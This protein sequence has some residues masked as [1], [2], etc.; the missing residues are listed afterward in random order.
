M[1]TRPTVQR[2][3]PD[4]ESEDLLA[5]AREI[6][7]EELAPLAAEYEEKEI[8]P[9]EQF[10]ILG[11]AG[12][13]GLPYPERWGGGDVPYEVYLQVLEEIAAAW[14]S[15]GVGLS[16]H[17]MSCYALAHYGSDEQRDRW[18]PAMLGGDLL[19]AYALSEP[20]AGSDAAAL[21]TRARRDGDAYVVNGVK[22]WTTHGGQAD[23]YTTMVRTS[24]DGGKGISCLLVD[25]DTPGMSAAP[26]ERKMGLTGSTTA[27]MIFEDARVDADR[28]IGA[29][30][31]GLRIALSSLASGR[32]GIAA[33]S[34]GLAQAALDEAVAYAKQRTQFGKPII[35]FQ[36][37]EFLLADMAAAVESAR[38]TYLDAARRRDR[39]LPF[40]KQSSIAK[41][42]ATDAAMKVTTDAVQVFGGAGYTRDFPVE[43]Y[44]R[45]A[46]V[47][48]IFEGTNQIQRLVIAR[49][50]RKAY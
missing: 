26:P 35:D 31:E 28:L 1:P 23:Y 21:S 32:L 10:R 50:L 16:V 11:S 8:F 20:H 3:L 13:L 44:M 36:G 9:R 45:E 49:E 15:V 29:E 33:C 27:Q 47:P 6:A 18:L 34:V 17:T 4:T 2:L 40:Q 7:R 30:G 46:K 42:V 24:D 48:Q 41:L 37:L 43:R 22:A 14:M 25:A 19:G 38:A 5:L 39:G 12:L